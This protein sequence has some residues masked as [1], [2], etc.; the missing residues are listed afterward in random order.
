MTTTFKKQRTGPSKA[1]SEAVM[2]R[3]DLPSMPR[4][5]QRHIS[6]RV[7]PRKLGKVVKI[8][9][10]DL[11]GRGAS[12]ALES[13]R[14]LVI[15]VQAKIHKWRERRDKTIRPVHIVVAQPKRLDALPG[16]VRVVI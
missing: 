12:G 14:D 7:T 3:S 9:T 5:E 10:P 2:I 16:Q 15:N 8:T 6:I 13:S 1:G 4:R 11:I